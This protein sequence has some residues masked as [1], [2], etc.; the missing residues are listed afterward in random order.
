[1]AEHPPVYEPT[2]AKN[3]RSFSTMLKGVNAEE[4]SPYLPDIPANV[5]RVLIQPCSRMFIAQC[6]SPTAFVRPHLIVLGVPPHADDCRHE[7]R[8]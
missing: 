8:R 2:T 3:A 5:A 4:N 7:F 6:P 1:M